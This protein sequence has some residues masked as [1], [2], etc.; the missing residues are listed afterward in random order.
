MRNPMRWL[1]A[2]TLT[3]AATSSLHAQTT[4]QEIYEDP[5]QASGLYYVYHEP[6]APQTKAPKGFRPFYISHYSRH[7]SRWLAD[8]KDY[9]NPL[10]TLRAADSAGVLTPLGQDVLKRMET[11]CADAKGHDG[12]LSP[13]GV[14][15][16]RG[17]AERMYSH[18]GKAFSK[19]AVVT[20]RSTQV[21]RCML[22]MDVFCERLK[23]FDPSIKVSKDASH[24]DVW[25]LIPENKEYTAYVD[26]HDV[27]FSDYRKS[28]VHPDRFVASMFSSQ[29][30][31]DSHVDK[32]DFYKRMFAIA[33]VMPNTELDIRFYD[34]FQPEEIFDMWHG[35][36]AWFYTFA[37]PNPLAGEMAY[38][39]ALESLK[40][41]LDTA[42]DYIAGGNHGAT[43]RFSHDTYLTALGTT[44]RL[45]G[46]LGQASDP[47]KVN[48][49][50]S[51]QKVSPMAG[52]IQIIFFRNKSGEIIVK[53]LHNETEVGIPVQTDIYPFYKW[54]D[55]RKYYQDTYDYESL[56]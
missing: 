29:E 47:S 16:H 27:F 53:F 55:V 45:D 51:C 52:N 14:R 44:L 40:Q 18:Y 48:E 17:I 25:Y 3:I 6:T 19:G 42:D 7:G 26:S 35:Y 46:F 9:T 15:Q 28:T 34:I 2:A 24:R 56:R 12:E 49:V 10:N 39:K 31:I 13:L 5:E 32:T 30:F 43:L 4:R 20:A 41:I 23:E 1:L 37:G 8:P 50:W 36:N 33:Q 11:V 21:P 54:E 22:S 38:H